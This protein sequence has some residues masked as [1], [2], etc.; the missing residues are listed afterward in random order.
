MY[1]YH[2]GTVPHVLMFVL[3]P[4][5]SSEYDRSDKRDWKE[6]LLCM[7]EAGGESDMGPHKRLIMDWTRQIR[8]RPQVNTG[9]NAGFVSG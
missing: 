2:S 9:A 6:Q 8:S 7:L 4:R 5:S 1:C 3:Q